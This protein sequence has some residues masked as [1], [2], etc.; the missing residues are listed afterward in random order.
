MMKIAQMALLSASLL[1]MPALA[2]N[3]VTNGGFEMV[4]PDSPVQGFQLGQNWNFNGNLTGWNS[5]PG[6]STNSNNAFNVLFNSATATTISPNTQYTASETQTLSILNY[7]DASPDGGNFVGLD[8]DIFANGALSQT[9]NGLTVGNEYQL[10]FFWAATQFQNRVGATTE[11]LDVSFGSSSFSTPTKAIETHGFDGWTSV[12]QRFT[13]TST[14]QLLSFLSVGSPT[15]LPPVAL[16]DGVS[17]S[18]VP[19]PSS[20]AMLVLG[21]GLVGAVARRRGRENR[22]AML[23]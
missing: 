21:F 8:G 10:S 13:A 19:E 11:R 23:G 16:L 3:L 17:V 9:I 6:S 22:Q 18:A 12:T 4:A 2:A 1:S 14:S 15:G 20:W 5:A 7:G